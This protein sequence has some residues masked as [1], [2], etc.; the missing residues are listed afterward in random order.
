MLRRAAEF[1]GREFRR[2]L[3]HANCSS[4][5][6]F[7]WKWYPVPPHRPFHKSDDRNKARLAAGLFLRTSRPA[8]SLRPGRAGF[9]AGEP[10]FVPSR[11]DGAEDAG[12]VIVQV[13]DSVVCRTDI[14]GLDARD[15][16]ARPLFTARLKHHVPF[17]LHGT[18]TPKLF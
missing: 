9:Y 8:G 14:V 11:P 6:T 13:F 12:F 4:R 15:V 2:D 5:Q 1:N 10:L 16:A 7:L 17:A 3:R 18:F